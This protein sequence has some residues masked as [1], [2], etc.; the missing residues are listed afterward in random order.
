MQVALLTSEPALPCSQVF[1][2]FDKPAFVA[3]LHWLAHA[4]LPQN[5]ARPLREQRM[6]PRRQTESCDK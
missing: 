1:E 6:L 3:S 4:Y 2:V 5:Y